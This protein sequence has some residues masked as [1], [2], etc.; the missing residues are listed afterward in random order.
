MEK[1]FMCNALHQS[2]I[3]LYNLAL[4]SFIFSHSRNSLGKE[5]HNVAP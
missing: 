5:F 1:T 4:K 2:F 3:M